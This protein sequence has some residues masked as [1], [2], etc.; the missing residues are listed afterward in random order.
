MAVGIVLLFLSFAFLDAVAQLPKYVGGALSLG[1]VAFAVSNIIHTVKRVFVVTY[2]PLIA[3]FLLDSQLE[4][5]FSIIYICYFGAALVTISVYLNRGMAIKMAARQV[6]A[7]GNGGSLWKIWT[8]PKISSFEIEP[9]IRDQNLDFRIFISALWIYFFFGSVFFLINV[10]G[11]T[12]QDYSSVI[13]QTTGIFN[14]MGTLVL[15]FYLDPVLA[16]VF[17]RDRERAPLAIRSVLWAQFINFAFVSPAFFYL[18]S[19]FLF[20]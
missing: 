20:E 13:L 18:L 10:L 16:R 9:G 4:D 15:A 17:E 8:W 1:G 7:F 2:P 3:I 6:E 19:F 12:L 11:F 14:A 5:L